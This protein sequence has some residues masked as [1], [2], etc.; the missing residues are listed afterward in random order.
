MSESQEL[1]NKLILQL[2]EK[3]GNKNPTEIQIE[4]VAS[5][6]LRC[7]IEQRL[8]FHHKLSPRES[9]CLLLAAHGKTVAEIASVT[10]VKGSTVRTWRNNILSKL[11]SRSMAQ[12]VYKGIQYGYLSPLRME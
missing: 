2:L 9:S 11:C 10:E 5:L 6:L 3:L 8:F 4:L 1:N 7:T 12:A